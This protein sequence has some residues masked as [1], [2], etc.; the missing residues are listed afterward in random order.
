[1]QTYPKD[2]F[3]PW[4]LVWIQFIY[5][6]SSNCFNVSFVSL[7]EIYY[8]K[9]RQNKYKLH[10]L[11]ENILPKETNQTVNI[12]LHV[13]TIIMLDSNQY[14]YLI[15]HLRNKRG[16]SKGCVCYPNRRMPIIGHFQVYWLG[17]SISL[18]I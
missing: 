12:F 9:K 2:Y 6:I 17:W 11:V 14:S 5:I 16:S 18:H 8:L 15:S 10:A 1:M 13:V 7:S 4:L 3:S